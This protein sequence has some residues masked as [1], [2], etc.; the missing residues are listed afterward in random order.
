M[1]DDKLQT[2]KVKMSALWTFGLMLWIVIGIILLVTLALVLSFLVTALPKISSALNSVGALS[3]AGAGIYGGSSSGGSGAGS[4]YGNGSS[5]ASSQQGNA[6][7]NYLQGLATQTKSDVDGGN[8]SGA[9]SELGAINST[10]SQVPSSQLP[11]WLMPDLA[12]AGQAI[13]NRNATAFDAIY[14]QISQSMG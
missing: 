6:A 4:S 5:G 7:L 2:V 13:T 11:S 10:L 9:A 8:W 3:S 1:A 14:N 12:A